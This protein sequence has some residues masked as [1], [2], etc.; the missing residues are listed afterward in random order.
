M[1]SSALSACRLIG[2]DLFGHKGFFCF[3]G[4]GLVGIAG[5]LIGHI[6]LIGLSG[7]SGISG[8]V[9]QISLISL[10]RLVGLGGIGGIGGIGGFRGLSLVNLFIVAI[11]SLVGSSTLVDFRIIIGFISGFVGLG[12]FISDISLIGYVSLIGSSASSAR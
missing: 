8:L 6:S 11:I 2:L 3:I 9:G 10:I 5:L 4:L 1:G 12:R 7:F